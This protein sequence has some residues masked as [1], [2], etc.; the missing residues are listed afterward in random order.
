MRSQNGNGAGEA[1]MDPTF[2]VGVSLEYVF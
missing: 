1:V 2:A